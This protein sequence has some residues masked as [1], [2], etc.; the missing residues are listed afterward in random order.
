MELFKYGSLIRDSALVSRNY[1]EVWVHFLNSC[2]IQQ[3][4]FGSGVKKNDRSRQKIGNSC[5]CYKYIK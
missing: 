1:F 3:D 5:Q 4:D 2:C